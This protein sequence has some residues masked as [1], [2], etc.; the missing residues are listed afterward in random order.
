[1]QCG[2]MYGLKPVPFRASSR[3]PS[4]AHQFVGGSL[5]QGSALGYSPSSLRDDNPG[6]PGTILG[7]TSGSDVRAKA[8]TFQSR[9]APPLRGSSVFGRFADPGLRPGLFSL[10]PPG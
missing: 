8:R 6:S 2:L 3:R 4:G 5:T 10:I 9:F 7:H 1:M